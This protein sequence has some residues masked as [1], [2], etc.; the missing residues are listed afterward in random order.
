LYAETSLPQ[1]EQSFF[2]MIRWHLNGGE[3]RLQLLQFPRAKEKGLELNYQWHEQND[4]QTE[5]N[6][7]EGL[8]Q[9][10]EFM[11]GPD[12]NSYA[13]QQWAVCIEPH[14]RLWNAANKEWGYPRLMTDSDV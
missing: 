7:L 10:I 13:S 8:D 6:C 12:D 11:G 14:Q 1:T 3:I 4:L 9:F 2:G 5:K